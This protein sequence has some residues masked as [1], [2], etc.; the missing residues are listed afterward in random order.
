MERKNK[1]TKS[2][3]NG[4]GTLYY[5]ETLGCWVFQYYD[6]LGKR[7]TMKQRKKESKKDFNARVTKIKND[8]NTG[9]YICKSSETIVSIAKQ[10]IE[11]KHTDGTTSGRSYKRELETLEQ[12]KKTCPKFCNIPIQNVTIK[13]L[14]DAKKEIKKY[15]NS[16]IDKIWRLLEKTF[17]IACSPSRKILIYNLMQDENLKKPIS[18]QKTKKVKPLTR[19]E[20]EKL[21]SIL[22]NEERNHP[23]R[24]I[25]KMQIISGMRIG[26]VLARSK[27]DYIKETQEFNIHNTL[28]QDENY[29][30]ILGEHTKTYNKKTQIDEGQ[31]YLP[32]DNNLFS[33]LVGIIEE[34]CNK[35]I[36]NMYNLLFWD[37]EKNTFITPS[38][39]NSWIKRLNAKYKICSLELSTHRLRHTA[40]T[41][42]KEIGIDLSAIQYLA[43]H[44]EG[45][46]ITEEV[47]IETS[48]E[49]VKDQVAKIS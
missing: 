23:Y 26:E 34:Q 28:T 25:V 30:V 12:I 2:V 3:G 29:H 40:L 4:E 9:T 24:N 18:E 13:H 1:R 10:Y 38:E 17:S 21:N 47:Y 15:A 32:L 35:K 48:L 42:W 31:R 22:D 19:T 5:S 49:F 27:K 20:I 37:Y 11:N 43:G 46:D 41:H 8:L 6:T 44:V 7:Q 45:S 33:E 14:E 36:I 16:V 39:V